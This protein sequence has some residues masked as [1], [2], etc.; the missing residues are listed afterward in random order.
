MEAA[1]ITNPGF[2]SVMEVNPLT[3]G[4]RDYLPPMLGNLQ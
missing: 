1:F 3:K 2:D 4:I